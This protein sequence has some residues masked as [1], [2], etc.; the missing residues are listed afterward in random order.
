MNSAFVSIRNVCLRGAGV[1]LERA[2]LDRGD[3]QAPKLSASRIAVPASS[4]PDL[5]PH[6]AGAGWP[7]ATHSRPFRPRC[8][9]EQVQRLGAGRVDRQDVR[10][11]PLRLH[12]RLGLADL[13]DDVA[14][15]RG[16]GAGGCHAAP[17]DLIEPIVDAQPEVGL[18][19]GL[20]DRLRRM[21][22]GHVRVDR[23]DLLQLARDE[24]GGAGD[25]WLRGDRVERP[26]RR[27]PASV[28][29]AWRMYWT[30]VVASLTAVVG[31]TG[32]SQRWSYPSATPSRRSG[33]RSV[34]TVP[35]PRRARYSSQWIRRPGSRRSRAARTGRRAT[36]PAAPRPAPRRGGC[37]PEGRGL[38][39]ALL[40][41][42]LLLPCCSGISLLLS[43]WR[44]L[45]RSQ[46]DRRGRVGAVGRDGHVVQGLHRLTV[47]RSPS[48]TPRPTLKRKL[49]PSMSPLRRPRARSRRAGCRAG[50]SR[51]AARAARRRA[52]ACPTWSCPAPRSG[53][54]SAAPARRRPGRLRRRRGDPF[55]EAAQVAALAP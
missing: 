23:R 39:G 48:Q 52:A 42:A 12:D 19:D 37:P 10:L 34:S 54:G 22:P 25:R 40:R 29:P 26:D 13:V 38:L 11:V 6:G 21:D 27:V 14:G 36:G 15:D 20:E 8:P 16:R 35:P 5:S 43:G 47:R 30:G 44:R 46:L 33:F 51:S 31:S 9:Y 55:A 1:L 53:R 17:H 28:R 4:T 49:A 45:A 7:G 24:L 18:D 50:R 41:R 2:Q 32:N 3:V